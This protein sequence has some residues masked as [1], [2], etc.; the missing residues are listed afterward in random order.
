MV[1]GLLSLHTIPMPPQT[2][3]LQTSNVVHGLPSSQGFVLFAWTQPVAGL[4]LSVVQT[5]SSLQS[6]AVPAWQPPS[7]QT[8]P[9]V[10]A[11]PSLQTATLFAWEQ[12]ATGLQAS[13][14]QGLLSLQSRGTPPTQEADA[15]QASPVVQALPSSQV[16]PAGRAVCVHPPAAVHPS[17]FERPGPSGGARYT[18]CRR[19][20]S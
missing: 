11:F 5:L 4:Q 15:L 14:V 19:P 13:V 3:P 12:P 20:T 2:P 6:T 10:Q 7:L 9:V 8:S 18:W 16:V 17:I 1:H